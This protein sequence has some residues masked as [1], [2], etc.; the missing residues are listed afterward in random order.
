MVDHHPR[1]AERWGAPSHCHEF[2]PAGNVSPASAPLDVTIDTIAPPVTEALAL[3]TGASSSDGITSGCDPGRLGRPQ[4]RCDPHRRW[5]PVRHDGADG[6][7]AWTF[8]PSLPDGPHTIVASETD[9]AGNLASASLDVTLLT[10]APAIPT[11]QG[12]APGSDSGIDG[13]GITNVAQPTVVGTADAGSTVVLSDGAVQVGNA[14]ADPWFGC[15]VDHHPGTLS[16]GEYLLTSTSSDAAGNASPDSAPL[17]VTIDTTVTPV[18]EALALDTGASSSDG[19]TSDAT[20][21]GSGDPNAFVTLTVGTSP[22]ATTTADRTGAWTFTPS[23]PD[24]PHTIVASETDTAGNLASASLDVTLLTQGPAIPTIQGLAPGSDSGIDGDGITNVAQP[25]VVGTADAGSTV[26][27]S[28]G[29]V[30]VGSAIADPVS[31]AWSIVASTLSDGEHLLT[32]T[33]SDAAGNASPASAPLDVTIDTIAPPVTEALALDTGASSSDGITSDATLVGS[34]DPNAV[35]TLT[36]DG[37]P[38]ATTGADGTGAWTFTPSLPDVARIR[39]WPAKP[40]PPAI[41]LR[42]RW[43][44]PC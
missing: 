15:V 39:S 34:G 28:D 26:V 33:S 4:R 23:L 5:V 40:T 37:S 41:L 27:L 20:L 30:P 9:T 35:V 8:T 12:L 18:T 22:L 11:I 3:D 16:D 42:P 36:V 25:T 29:T 44:S 24:G 13:D 7:G 2:D 19:I 6:T 1:H 43:T 21:V 38:F 14:I 10:Q 17:D 31:G 32:A